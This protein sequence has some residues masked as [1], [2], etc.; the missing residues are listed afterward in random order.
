[1]AIIVAMAVLS[2]LNTLGVLECLEAHNV[3]Y[4]G[5]VTISIILVAVLAPLIIFILKARRTL[6]RWADMFERNT[7]VKP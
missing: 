4:I 2:I 3:D 7:I 1:M 6:D 5:D